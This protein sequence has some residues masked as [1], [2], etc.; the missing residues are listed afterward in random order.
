[1]MFFLGLDG[2]PG[3]SSAPSAEGAAVSGNILIGLF[4]F[5]G[6]LFIGGIILF[7]FYAYTRYIGKVFSHAVVAIP[8]Q[9]GM[10]F[11]KDVIKYVKIGE[12]FDYRL[13]KARHH[14][15]C[16]PDYAVAQFNNNKRIVFVRRHHTH[17][18]KYFY[19]YIKYWKEQSILPH[20][21]T[22]EMTFM[23]EVDDTVLSWALD[24]VHYIHQKYPLISQNTM[25]MNIG[26]V[27]VSIVCFV[28]MIVVVKS[29]T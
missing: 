14:I 9:N 11:I 19:S 10:R 20:E 6:L 8:T 12:R 2:I 17:D 25:S 23:E 27:I 21:D 5:I 26:I 18:G 13:K 7:T 28:M 16:P 15:P 24:K 1:M 4:L 22:L 29:L 3:L